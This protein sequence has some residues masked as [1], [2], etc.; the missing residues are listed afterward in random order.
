MET[1]SGV[2]FTGQPSSD[3]LSGT[4]RAHAIDRWIY[5]LMAGW[6]IAIV[7]AGFVP[8]SVQNLGMIQAHQ[9]PAYPL[10]AH[11]H[12]VLMGSFMLLLLAQTVL[13]AAG[14]QDLHRGLGLI[15]MGLV[16]ALVVV[17]FILAPTTY[18]GVWQ[19][20]QFGP[21]P[22]KAALTPVLGRL[23]NI[24]LLQI[25]VGVLFPL[26]IGIGLWARGRDAGLHKRMMILATAVTLAAAFARIDWLP[27]MPG[28]ALSLDLYVLLTVSPMFVWDIVRNRSVHR[29]YWLWLSI[30]A[31]ASLIVNL[32]WNT[33]GWHVTARH[34]MGA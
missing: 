1:I 18:H 23:E 29:A 17:G 15:A 2:S 5:V 26:F 11:I 3:V 4:P 20:A 19:G 6:F 21:P 14:R 28:S 33:P 12:A 22:V 16:P 10:V 27:K 30:Y 34:L 7:L 31:A 32:L 8:D 9:R 13:V 25:R 24:L